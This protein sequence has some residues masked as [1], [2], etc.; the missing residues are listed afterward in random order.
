M[1]SQ[2]KII[3]SDRVKKLIEDHLEVTKQTLNLQNQ[4][5]SAS[6]VIADSL[7]NEGKL[8]ICGNG[9]SAADAQHIAA[10]FVGRFMK[11]RRPLPAIALH[12]NTSS[13]TAIGNDYNYDQV[14]VREVLA[15]GGKADV[16]L[17][18][19]TSGNSKNVVNAAI[20][21]KDKG[22]KVISFT[23][24]AGGKLKEISDLC[25]CIPST[26]TPRIQEIHILVGHIICELVED[27]VC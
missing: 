13:L 7:S 10:E 20:A 12:V 23:G 1:D 21:A 9:G 25:L 19:S 26:C 6:Q 8:L 15:H 18:I 11:E 17:A 4:V 14:F 27:S 16:L 22:L 5:A 3:T 2:L 24:A